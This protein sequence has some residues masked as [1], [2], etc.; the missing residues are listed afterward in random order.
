[1]E[2]VD[3]SSSVIEDSVTIGRAVR[4]R[5][6]GADGKQLNAEFSVV[7]DG[8]AFSLIIE[9][10]GGRVVGSAL[11]RNSDYVPLFELLLGRLRELEAVISGA[12][13]V[14]ANA[15]RLEATERQLIS[16][17]I[18]MANVSDIAR[19]RLELTRAQGRVGLTSAS[20]KEGNNR[21]R[22]LLRITVPDYAPA[23][24]EQLATD[25]SR[26][27]AALVA[28]EPVG[29]T[30]GHAR[31]KIRREQARLRRILCGSG[32]TGVCALCGHEF[33]TGLL[34]A[35]HIKKRQHCTP[36]ERR[37]LSNVAM[38]ACTFGCD[39][40]YEDGWVSVDDSGRLIISDAATTPAVRDR[41]AALTGSACGAHKVGSEPYF[42]WHRSTVF[43]RG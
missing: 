1:M 32:E 41:L 13:V 30:D 40:L 42:A 7:A 5:A 36:D 24:A 35:A 27:G 3:A 34:V 43:R 20:K 26:S 23:D 31:V 38:L 4:R 33:P 29:E 12:E 6:E 8:D 14:S 9:S 11:P 17:P 15:T 28:E 10:A 19:L 39:A 25:L 22:V 21:K 37:D 16:S 2:A 18:V